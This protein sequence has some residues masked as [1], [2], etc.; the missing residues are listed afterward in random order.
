MPAAGPTALVLALLATALVAAAGTALV[1]AYARRARLLDAPG[2][3]RSHAAPTPRGGGAG[4]LLAWLAAL[5]VV[6]TLGLAPGT[7]ASWALAAGTLAVALV[8]LLDDHR[9][10]PAWPRLLIHALAAA[11]LLL[12]VIGVP[13]GGRGWLAWALLLPSLVAVLNFWNFMDGID[14]IAGMQT[15]FVATALALS[16]L[17]AG[18]TALALASGLLAAAA[19]GFLPFNFPRARIFLGDVGSGGLGFAVA[20]LLLLGWARGVLPAGLALLLPSAFLIDAGLTLLSRMLRKRRWYTAHREHLYQWL[21]RRGRSHAR[22]VALFL[23]W[24]LLIVTP[25]AIAVLV[26]RANHAAALL[27][28]LLCGT[29]LW[30]GVRVSMLSRT[31]RVQR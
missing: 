18:D 20:G 5:A 25:L 12:S 8:G 29:A 16:A 14:G 10:L 24:N 26:H 28:A 2:R 15:L 3:R 11:V 22:V 1:L 23:A 19:A 4:P 21:V 17:L 31:A 13:A 27:A 7:V 6:A 30:T 9:P